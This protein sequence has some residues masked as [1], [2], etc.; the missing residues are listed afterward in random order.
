[1]SARATRS[2]RSSGSGGRPAAAPASPTRL[3]LDE[4][5][6]LSAPVRLVVDEGTAEVLTRVTEAL[7]DALAA[8]QA[9]VERRIAA[10]EDLLAELSRQVAEVRAQLERFGSE[11]PRDGHSSGAAPRPTPPTT[12]WSGG[13]V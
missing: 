9:R 10:V 4:P 13:E 6:A 3:P 12:P 8:P 7:A 1:M 5:G 11:R 2:G